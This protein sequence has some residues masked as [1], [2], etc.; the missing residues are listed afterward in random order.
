M[1]SFNSRVAYNYKRI[2]VTGVRVYIWWMSGDGGLCE[3][4]A[5]DSSGP[6]MYVY[7]RE[8]TNYKWVLDH[9]T[10]QRRCWWAV[11]HLNFIINVYR[12]LTS[13]V[14]CLWNLFNRLRKSAIYKGISD[15]N[16]YS[17]YYSLFICVCKILI[18]NK[19]DMQPNIIWYCLV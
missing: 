3:N 10:S 18:E 8:V 19:T 5:I 17:T 16:N 6:A 15:C 1:I 12:S 7:T 9:T 14:M 13:S 4:F 2:R 11:I